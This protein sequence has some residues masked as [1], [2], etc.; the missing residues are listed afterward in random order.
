MQRDFSLK[1]KTF[2]TPYPSVPTKSSE[3][4]G[5]SSHWEY[6]NVSKSRVTQRVARQFQPPL[7][8]HNVCTVLCKFKIVKWSLTHGIK[9]EGG[10]SVITVK[11][12]QRSVGN[13]VHVI[14]VPGV[15]VFASDPGGRGGRGW[16]GK[17]LTQGLS[18]GSTVYMYVCTQQGVCTCI[19]L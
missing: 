5:T 8:H 15:T 11:R 19:C 4:M 2:Q 14:N 17:G 12:V 16:L 1:C 3:K 9:G 18:H 10:S 13:D 6:A 7:Q